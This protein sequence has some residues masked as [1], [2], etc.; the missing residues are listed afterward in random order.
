MPGSHGGGRHPNRG[1]IEGAIATVAADL[2]AIAQSSTIAEAFAPGVDQGRC[3]PKDPDD[4]IGASGEVAV[5]P[6]SGRTNTHPLESI[7]WGSGRL[8]GEDR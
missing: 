4:W 1:L 2:G 6:Q 8:H 3:Q 7:R 5:A